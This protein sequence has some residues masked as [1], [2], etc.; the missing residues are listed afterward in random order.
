MRDRACWSMSSI[1][2]PYAPFGRDCDLAVLGTQVWNTALG[3]KVPAS[4]GTA[5]LPNPARDGHPQR[6]DPLPHGWTKSVNSQCQ[7]PASCSI[8]FLTDNRVV[9]GQGI[10]GESRDRGMVETGMRNMVQE[11]GRW[12]WQERTGVCCKEFPNTKWALAKGSEVEG[13]GVTHGSS[14]PAPPFSPHSG[15][16]GLQGYRQSQRIPGGRRA[17]LITGCR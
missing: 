12:T 3:P 4:P 6:L 1:R 16:R 5:Q 15:A 8:A 7:E 14:P 17:G 11:A 9:R 13:A 2:S 10:E